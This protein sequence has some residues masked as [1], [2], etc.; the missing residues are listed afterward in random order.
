MGAMAPASPICMPL[1]Y[2]PWVAVPIAP[3]RQRR[4]KS[5]EL[6]QDPPV[7]GRVGEEAER[8]EQ[9]DDRVE[10]ARPALREA[11]HVAARVAQRGRGPSLPGAIQQLLQMH[12]LAPQGLL[13]LLHHHHHQQQ[14]LLDPLLPLLLGL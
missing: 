10:A 3:I 7:V 5:R 4:P 1:M 8:G 13:L 11:P 14:L 9:V 6:G 12:C 2:M